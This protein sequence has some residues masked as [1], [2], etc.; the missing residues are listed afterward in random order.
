MK[1]IRIRFVDYARNDNP[2]NGLAY[3]LI[4]KY[5]EVDDCGA[6]DY[7]ICFGQGLSHVQYDSCV[8]I[9][10]QGENSTPNFNDYDYAVGYDHLDFGDRYLRMPL[11]P[12]WR[13]PFLMLDKRRLEN[14]EALLRRKFCSFVVSNANFGDPMRLKFFERLSK[15]KKV[16]SGGR[17][18]NN[19]GGPVKDKLEF[20]KGYKFNIAF[21]NSSFPGYVTEKVMEAYAAQTVPIYYGDPTVETDFLPESMVCV[22][23]E[24]DIDR[25]VDEVV[26]LDEDDDAYLKKVTAPC[27]AY[28]DPKMYEKRLE[29][30]LVHIFDQPL[31]AARRRCFYG[32]QQMMRQHMR[33]VLTVDQWLCDLRGKLRI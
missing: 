2:K 24:A 18:M 8:K 3:R 1:R 30:F 13:K 29:A 27:L 16:D 4:S 9:L 12:F 14:P 22:R 6:A 17:W 5:F 20:C 7:A 33:K 19:V 23:N 31:E 11:Y 26:A 32:H 15:Y 10:M 28:D 25:A 21:E